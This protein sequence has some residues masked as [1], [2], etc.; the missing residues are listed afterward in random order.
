MANHLKNICK[1][2]D[3]FSATYDTFILLGDFN[4]ETEEE[5]F[6][7][8]LNLCNL[9]NLVKQNFISKIQINPHV[10]ISF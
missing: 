10:L 8:F 5:S 2:L 3:K 7:E 4:A 9:K 1:T 6:A